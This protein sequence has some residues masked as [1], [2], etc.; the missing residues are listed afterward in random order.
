MLIHPGVVEI[1]FIKE[2][3]NILSWN[4]AFYLSVIKVS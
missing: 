1:V 4:Y 2:G 3:E